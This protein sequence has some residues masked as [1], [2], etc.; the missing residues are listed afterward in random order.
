MGTKSKISLP[1]NVLRHVELCAFGALLTTSVGLVVTP[2]TADAAVQDTT[3]T[4]P[5]LRVLPSVTEPGAIILRTKMTDA[6][7]GEQVAQD[8]HSSHS[9]HSSHE[10]HASHSSHQSGY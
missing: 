7:T 6:V 10:S 8:Y 5:D 9:S 3:A 4:S 1:A 2:S